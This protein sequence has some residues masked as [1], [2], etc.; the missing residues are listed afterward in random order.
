MD[1]FTH[2]IPEHI[3]CVYIYIYILYAYTYI[4]LCVYID[5]LTE[6]IE[7]E[8]EI[9]HTI[10]TAESLFLLLLPIQSDHHVPIRGFVL[11]AM[12][13]PE[14]QE[15]AYIPWTS[16]VELPL[17]TLQRQCYYGNGLFLRP[18]HSNGL[19]L[20]SYKWAHLFFL[21]ALFLTK[22]LV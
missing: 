1:P 10:L 4:Y 6:P 15:A 22:W 13:S 16:W 20:V 3:R 11:W 8:R 5:L 19:F 21:L 14:A 18:R 12:Q 2:K 17:L 9:E 7:G